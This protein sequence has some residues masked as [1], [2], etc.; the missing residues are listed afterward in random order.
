MLK[1]YNPRL[2]DEET[3]DMAFKPTDSLFDY[4]TDHMLVNYVFGDDIHLEGLYRQN[5]ALFIV[6]S[7]P[8]V[9][10]DHPLAEEIPSRLADQGLV[11]TDLKSPNEFYVHGGEAGALIIKDVHADNVVL[12]SHT[13]LLHPIDIH[14]KF[15]GLKS[16]LAALHTLG[17]LDA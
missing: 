3:G 5:G 2:I 15:G 6:I 13:G 17:L 12:G 8:F 9:A 4:I 14:F 7:Q 11:Q 16:R 10:G 1:A